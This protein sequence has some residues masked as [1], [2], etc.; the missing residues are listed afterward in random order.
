MEHTK[1]WSTYILIDPRVPIEMGIF[2]VGVTNNIKKRYIEHLNCQEVNKAK[3]A[4]I[5]E[6][7]AEGE[8]PICRTV[9]KSQ[10]EREGRASEHRWIEKCIELGMPLT[11]V[12][13][14]GKQR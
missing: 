5:A 2:Y 13:A 11:N 9:E 1:L 6:I 10:T 14:T 8:V 4:L 3:N 12:E 7:L